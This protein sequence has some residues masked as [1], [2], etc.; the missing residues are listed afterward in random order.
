LPDA[1]LSREQY[2]QKVLEAYQQTPGTRG[3][4]RP[5]DRLLALQ[6][7][8][9]AIPLHTIENALV[10]AAA[11][12]IFRPADAPPLTTVRSLAYFV[13]VI[14]ELL[15][16]QVSEDYFEYLRRKLEPFYSHHPHANPPLT[17]M[18]R[19]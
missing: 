12:R 15:T 19:R 10:L 14:E 11:R 18:R 5:P 9:R 7:Q 16:T 4:V 8:Q 6:L 1:P 17:L 13:P 2:V 3:H